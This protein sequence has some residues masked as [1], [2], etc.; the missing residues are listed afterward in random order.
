MNVPGGESVKVRA[1]R[2]PAL[3]VLATIFCFGAQ[4]AQAYL[5]LTVSVGSTPT[6]LKWNEARVRWFATDRSV[7]GVSASQFQT[8]VASAFGTWEEVPTASIAFQFVGFTGAVPFDDDEI[9]VFGFDA[10]PE[11]ERVL[12]ATSFV[13]DTRTGAIVES[14]VF[15]NSIFLWS[16][17][18]TGDPA[19]FDL[20]SVAAHEI[21]HF[22]G[23]GHSALGETEV[24]PEGGRRVFASGA[25]M[26]PISLGRGVTKDRT[27]QPDDIAGVSDL[28]PDGGFGDSTG[29]IAGRV[30]KNGAGVTGAHVVAFDPETG[31]LVGAFA[32]GA[33]GAFQ[34]AG[35]SPGA[36]VV[37]VEPLDDADID[38]FFA[39]LDVDLD[40]QVTFHSRLVVA[41][42]GGTSNPFDVAVRP[43]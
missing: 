32:V 25:V 12:G 37:R 1:A 28:Y 19:R 20:Q 2:V 27:L 24:R 33:G 14:D 10:E 30:Q 23:L 40:F 35:L 13:F 18:A 21:G 26:F 41:P 15:F 4:P 7:P 39:S 6:R 3:V 34:I 43:K 38:S 8:A 42:A 5:H 16:T 17:S 29:A 11:L 31:A 9:S 36:H 22:V